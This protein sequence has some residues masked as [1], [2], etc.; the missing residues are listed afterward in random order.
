MVRFYLDPRQHG[1]SNLVDPA[2]AEFQGPAL[3]AYNDASFTEQDWEGIQKPQCSN[4]AED[5]LKVG[6]FGIGFNSI[7]HITGMQYYVPS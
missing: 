3:L 1:Q 6:K 4:K 2:L 5:P 7:Y